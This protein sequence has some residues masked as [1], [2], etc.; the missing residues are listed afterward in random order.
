M[1]DYQTLAEIQQDLSA[2]SLRC[3]DLVDFY[4]ERIASSQHLNLFVE[5]F[6]EEARAKA[7]ET[8]RKIAAGTAGKLAGLVIGIKDILCYQGHNLT[9]GSGILKGFESLFTATA[10]ARLLAED[11]I[12]IGRQNCDEFAMGSST[13]TSIYG[14]AHNPLDPSRVTGGSSGASAAAV[15]ANLCHAALGSDTGGSVRQPASFCGV[16]GL[17]P[18]YGRVSRWG[19]IAYASSFDQIGPLTRSVEDAAR[20]LEVMAGQDEYDNTSSSESVSDYMTGLR[21]PHIQPHTIGYIREA[22]ES[23]GIDIEIRQRILQLLEELKA[24]G[25]TIKALD[26]PYLEYVVPCYYILTTAEASSNLSRFDGVH[27]GPRSQKSSDLEELYIKSRTEGFGPEVRKRIMLGSFVLSSGYYDAYYTQAMKV[28]RL[29]REK[30][31]ELFQSCDYIL[32]PTAPTPAFRLGEKT[33]DPVEMYL[34]DIYT[35]HANLAGIPAVSVP[36]GMHSSGLPF[37]VQLMGK[38]FDEAGLLNFAS[39]ISTR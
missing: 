8:D 37:G 10:V 25:H 30:T 18:T 6:A 36:A 15:S 16:V 14:P 1:K 22:V 17:K 29:I 20:I 11:A 13:E 23:E 27:Y 7:V 19:L 2:G 35:V 3:K 9:A 32:L 34:S 28:R 26:F 39:R 12:I 21:E 5:V 33:E 31:E 38:R 24:Q 4:L